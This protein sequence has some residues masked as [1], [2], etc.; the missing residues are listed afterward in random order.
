MYKGEDK[1]LEI[2]IKE[3]NTDNQESRSPYW[4]KR[5]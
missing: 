5:G 2:L 4:N 1:V 3:K